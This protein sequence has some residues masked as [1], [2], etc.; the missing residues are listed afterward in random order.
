MHSFTH[1]HITSAMAARRKSKSKLIKSN[2]NYCARQAQYVAEEG[3]LSRGGVTCQCTQCNAPKRPH[4]LAWGAEHCDFAWLHAFYMRPPESRLHFSITIKFYTVCAIG[5]ARASS[6]STLHAICAVEAH[7]QFHLHFRRPSQ[8]NNGNS[9]SN[10]NKNNKWSLPHCF[11][12]LAE[13]TLKWKI[14]R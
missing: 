7:N 10:S 13:Y 3:A 9:H 4:S 5:R 14:S 1:T 8:H 2:F 6:C 11:A 12:G